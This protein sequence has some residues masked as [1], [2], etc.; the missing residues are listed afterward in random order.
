M[1]WINLEFICIFY[2]LYK[3]WHLIN[4]KNPFLNSFLWFYLFSG[5]GINF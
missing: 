4:T 5:L 3:F 1:E 2:K